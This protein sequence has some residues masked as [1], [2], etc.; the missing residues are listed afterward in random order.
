MPRGL[1]R[2]SGRYLLVLL[3]LVLVL[4]ACDRAPAADESGEALPEPLKIA[5][6]LPGSIDDGGWNESAHRG[7][8]ELQSDQGFETT[9]V[10]S[11]Q[12]S[13]AQSVLADL[14]VQDYDLIFGHGIEF[15]D[16]F[17]HLAPE[18]PDTWFVLTGVSVQQEPNVASMD[19]DHWQQGYF[20][21]AAAALFTQSGH[22]GLLSGPAI[23]PLEEHRQGFSAGVRHIEATAD[24]NVTLHWASVAQWDDLVGAERQVREMMTQGVDVIGANA[25]EASEAVHRTVGEAGMRSIHSQALN[26]DGGPGVLGASASNLARAVS[27]MAEQ[28]ALGELKPET[29]LLGAREG[30]VVFALNPDA[31][32]A[33][34][35]EA[36][37]Q[38]M[39][40][41]EQVVSGDLN[42]REHD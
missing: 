17:L 31:D 22:V 30:I 25:N 14:V 32:P 27:W 9:V 11:V 10:Q 16:A 36:A 24:K 12:W 15:A 35:S 18:H 39:E 38:M 4:G 20:Q 34:D 23:P 26:F 2:T 13:E 29:Y 3:A 33:L 40:L 5:L 41:F 8:Q 28:A 42:L 37:R 21:G 19:T 6:M 7:L 1:I